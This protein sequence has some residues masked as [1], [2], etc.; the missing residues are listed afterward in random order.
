MA[1]LLQL[2]GDHGFVVKTAEVE[3]AEQAS[4]NKKNALRKQVNKQAAMPLEL[5]TIKVGMRVKLLEPDRMEGSG[6]VEHLEGKVALIKWE[7]GAVRAYEISDLC[8][9]ESVGKGDTKDDEVD[10]EYYSSAK[11]DEI[12]Y[13][14]HLRSFRETLK[15]EVKAEMQ[16]VGSLEQTLR[17]AVAEHSD[18]IAGE[19]RA[20]AE[21]M[22]DDVVR[23]QLRE[24][25]SSLEQEQVRPTCSGHVFCCTRPLTL[26]Q[27][28]LTH[29]P[30]CISSLS[31]RLVDRES[32]RSKNSRK[33]KKSWLKSFQKTRCQRLTATLPLLART[34]S[35]H[36]GS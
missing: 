13:R 36:R 27:P 14:Q 15:L 10:V 22:V 31:R 7:M 19:H 30:T 26:S 32:P 29:F 25:G 34:R 28:S 2:Y 11:L 4:M 5:S 23:M 24:E 9:A 17:S 6:I 3:K 33:K 8:A 35:P 21:Q 12:G 18:R 16:E 20:L 1:K